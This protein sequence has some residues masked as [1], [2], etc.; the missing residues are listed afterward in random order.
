MF[1]SATQL[2]LLQGCSAALLKEERA[3]GDGV[4]FELVPV[5]YYSSFQNLSG[6][7]LAV[8]PTCGE[9]FPPPPVATP[10]TASVQNLTERKAL[11]R[12]SAFL[13]SWLYEMGK[14]YIINRY[15]FTGEGLH[16][17]KGITSSVDSLPEIV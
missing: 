2:T 14:A 13:A 4:G 1:G 10:E 6:S 8:S 5:L 12:A 16:S 17:G 9:L 3:G 15:R 7:G 11:S